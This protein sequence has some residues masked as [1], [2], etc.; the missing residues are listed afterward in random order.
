MWWSFCTKIIECRVVSHKLCAENVLLCPFSTFHCSFYVIL[1]PRYRS[2]R[3]CLHEATWNGNNVVTTCFT[4][5]INKYLDNNTK[6]SVC[7]VD[8]PTPQSSQLNS[9][10]WYSKSWQRVHTQ[11][12][13]SPS[14]I[15]CGK[16]IFFK[17][18]EIFLKFWIER[19][20]DSADVAGLGA[21]RLG[22][23]DGM[24]GG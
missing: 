24:A 21:S 5:R 18:L 23:G 10:T 19:Y 16:K 4:Y 3:T 11:Q 13:V 20:L 17:D 12:H 22:E 6:I 15:F 7:T 8:L 2:R 14:L 1:L 9:S